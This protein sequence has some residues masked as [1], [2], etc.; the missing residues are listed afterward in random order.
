M[1]RHTVFVTGG[2]SGIG[3]GLA[4]AF[5]ARGDTVIIAGR[6]RKSLDAV[7]SECSGMEAEELD[8][9]DPASIAECA[10]R[11]TARHPALD[12]V[13]NNA[14]IQQILDFSDGPLP[15]DD[16]IAREIDINLKGL[17]LVSKA[18]LPVLRKQPKARLVHMGS[19][20]GYIPLVKAPVYSATKAAVHSF[21]ISLRRQLAE[22]NVQVVEIIP[23]VV[24]SGLHRHQTRRPPRAMPLDDFV[25]AAMAGL[26]AGRDEIPV[27]LARVLRIGSRI[28]PSM[29]LNIVNKAR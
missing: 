9:S 19:G 22:T 2:G 6:T 4:R 10:A 17:I 27:G 26:D 24:E 1:S 29:F 28:R 25:K 21:S 5:H 3:A 18:F 12:L 23:P 15:P 20:L 11:V 13:I 8:V 7:A 14:G 16:D